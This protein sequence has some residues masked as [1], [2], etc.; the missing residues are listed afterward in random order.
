[1]N[2]LLR[3]SQIAKKTGK[4]SRALRY[5]AELDL[6]I[7]KKRTDAGYRLYGEDA[8]L[9][10]EWIDK[11]TEIGFSLPEIQEFLG[12]F[13]D[14]EFAP[15]MMAELQILYREKL[16]EV[17]ASVIRLGKLATELKESIS[18][19][20]ICLQCNPTTEISHCKSCE[21]HEEESPLLI[22]VIAQ[23]F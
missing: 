9:K 16:L 20:S 13:K 7:P 1:M 21:K 12:S 17:E 4:T 22:S 5:Y 3:I 6:L 18:Y 8:I 10:I 14:L 11:L 2:S 23:S 15:D 19:T